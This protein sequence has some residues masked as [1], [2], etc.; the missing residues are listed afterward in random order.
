MYEDYK[1]FGFDEDYQLKYSKLFC[2]TFATDVS[3]HFLLS[4]EAGAMFLLIK[5]RYRNEIL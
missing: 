1:Q 3:N 2:D 5:S 4:T